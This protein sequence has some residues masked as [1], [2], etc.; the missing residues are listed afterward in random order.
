VRIGVLNGPNLN[1]LGKREPEHYGRCTLTEIESLLRDRASGASRD[2]EIVFFQSNEEAALVDWIQET[3]PSLDGFLVNAAAFTHT[4]VALREALAGARRP[5][6]E[7]HLSN[8][9]AREPF[10]RRSVIADLAVGVVAGFRKNSYLLALDGLLDY[11]ASAD[12]S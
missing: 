7:L 5:F 4:S 6:V 2:V 10:R 12:Q 9:H 3:A 1:L 8:V 11:L